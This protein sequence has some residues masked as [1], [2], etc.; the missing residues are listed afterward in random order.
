MSRP[1]A[2]PSRA[3]E[4]YAHGGVAFDME[5]D[6]D[7]QRF[8]SG[9]GGADPSDAGVPAAPDGGGNLTGVDASLQVISR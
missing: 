5:N 8:A 3:R 4:D 7:R 1:C 2:S 9:D 6:R